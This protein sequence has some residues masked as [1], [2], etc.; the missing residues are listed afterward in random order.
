MVVLLLVRR[1]NSGVDCCK[2]ALIKFLCQTWKNYL[3]LEKLG[4]KILFITCGKQCFKVPKDGSE[5]VDELATSKE[6][7]DTST[8]L[9][10]KHASS[11]YIYMVIVT[12]DTDVFIICL[13][14]FHQIT[15]ICLSDVEQKQTKTH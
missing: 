11:N 9:H 12:E 10:T 7:A 3:Y 14:I 15:D 8:L 2:T 5:V 1:Y 6:E 13:S 4:S